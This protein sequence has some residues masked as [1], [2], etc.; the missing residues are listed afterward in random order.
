MLFLRP[1]TT[2]DIAV[3]H[4]W[5]SYGN[6]FKQM[7]YA[8]REQGWLDE[9]RGRADTLIYTAI[10]GNKIIGFS[11]LKRTTDHEAEFRIALHPYEIGRGYG[12]TVTELTLKTGFKQ[13][14]MEGIT[15]IVRKS[16]PRAAQLYRS[17]GFA[18]TGESTHAIQGKDIDFIDM[19]MT[20]ER[21]NELT[22]KEMP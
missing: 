12:R 18:V 8:L 14:G 9:F 1:I 4:A 3:I 6:G 19:Y 22:I 21:F 15:L 17:I 10:S 13:L 16:N 20:R 5:P 7:D 2:E 11:L